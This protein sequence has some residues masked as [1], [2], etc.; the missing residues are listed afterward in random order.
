MFGDVGFVSCTGS[1]ET[2]TIVQNARIQVVLDQLVVVKVMKRLLSTSRCILLPAAGHD[3]LPQRR[4]F[5]E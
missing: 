4:S 3:T 2:L 1:R 5:S